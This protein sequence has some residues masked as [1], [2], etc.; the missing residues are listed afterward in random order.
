MT[1][2]RGDDLDEASDQAG[3]QDRVLRR[4][5]VRD[6]DRLATGGGLVIKRGNRIP[7]PERVDVARR[8]ECVAHDLGEARAGKR[9]AHGV[10]DVERRRSE[11]R[12]LLVRRHTG[13]KLVPADA[14]HLFGD[15]GLDRQVAP[16]RREDCHQGLARD[17]LDE[18]GL[19]IQRDRDHLAGDRFLRGDADPV[20]ETS[21]FLV[22]QVRAGQAVDPCWPEG[23][24]GRFGLGRIRVDPATSDR[25]VR[26]FADERSNPV[27][28]DPC[29]SR[30]LTL[31]EAQARL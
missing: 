3:A 30:L 14:R 15:V 12:H 23:Q 26:P 10:A 19:G 7:E 16:P 5:R 8:H 18:R 27:R 28:P 24:T 20:K 21:L 6:R 31:L 11:V 29:E 2:V 25:P 13:D 22:A 17:R 4:E 9:L 1:P